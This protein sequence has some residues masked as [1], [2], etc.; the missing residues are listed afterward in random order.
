MQREDGV[1]R[2]R[3]RL[4][5]CSSPR[6]TPPYFNPFS[7]RSARRHNQSPVNDVDGAPGGRTGPAVSDFSHDQVMNQLLVSSCFQTKKN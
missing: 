4:H 3:A 6:S 2:Q 5:E 7:L 1:A